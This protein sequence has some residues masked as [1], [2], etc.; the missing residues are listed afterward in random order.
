MHLPSFSLL[1][2][3]KVFR[4]FHLY[5]PDDI[6]RSEKIAVVPGGHA[7]DGIDLWRHWRWV[8]ATVSGGLFGSPWEVA[9]GNLPWDL[10]GGV[11]CRPSVVRSGF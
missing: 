7:A 3:A 9:V 6:V 10:A 5:V 1:P 4:S 2:S 8:Q 11:G